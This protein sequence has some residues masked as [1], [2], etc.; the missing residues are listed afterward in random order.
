LDAKKVT[1]NDSAKHAN[2][3]KR[4]KKVLTAFPFKELIKSRNPVKVHHPLPRNGP[5]F[6]L[7]KLIHGI[8]FEVDRKF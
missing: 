1:Y 2:K 8:Q 4:T 3:I 5:N 7:D 6:K